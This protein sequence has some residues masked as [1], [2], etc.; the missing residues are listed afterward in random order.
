MFPINRTWNNIILYIKYLYLHYYVQLIIIEPIKSYI[1]LLDQFQNLYFIIG[2]NGLEYK[3][4]N[5]VI[6]RLY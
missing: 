4:R 1:S 2:D 3:L 6:H 5:Y